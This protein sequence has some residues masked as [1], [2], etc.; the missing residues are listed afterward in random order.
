MATCEMCGRSTENLT[1]VKIERT[2]LEACPNCAKFGTKVQEA[3]MPRY[4]EG[5]NPQRREFTPRPA[6]KE[7]LMEI[8][9]DYANIIRSARERLGLKQEEFAKKLNEKESIMQ[10]IEAGSFTPSIEQARKFEKVLKIKLVEEISE[11]GEVPIST[12]KTGSEG[13]TMA[14]FIK[15]KLKK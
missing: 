1:K 4:V 5:Y 14:D 7:V 13:M 12:S 8:V 9:D 6:R 15:D 2:T 10:K 11:G 3:P